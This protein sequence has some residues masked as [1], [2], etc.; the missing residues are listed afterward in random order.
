[1][2]DYLTAHELADL[3]SCKPNQRAAMARWLEQNHW[4]FVID[5]SGLPKVARAYRDQKLGLTTE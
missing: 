2:S 3:V 1:M 5:K 4:R